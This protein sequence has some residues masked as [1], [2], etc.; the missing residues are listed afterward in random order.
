MSWFIGAYSGFAWSLAKG[1]HEGKYTLIATID[2][3]SFGCFVH[4]P[5]KVKN[6]A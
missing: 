4:T 1:K 5:R 6:L 3:L 2:G